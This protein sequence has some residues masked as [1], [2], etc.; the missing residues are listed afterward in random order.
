MAEGI[1]W[2]SPQRH[3]NK[4]PKNA[5]LPRLMKHWLVRFTNDRAETVHPANIVYAVQN[6]I[7]QQ[8]YAVRLLQNCTIR[9]AF[10][11]NA[12][13]ETV[14]GLSPRWSGPSEVPGQ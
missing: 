1:H 12:S 8:F 3:S 2:V 10:A 11:K 6:S 14:G 9:D 5:A 13:R 4:H 7:P